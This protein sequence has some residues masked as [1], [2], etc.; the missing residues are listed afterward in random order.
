V[1]SNVRWNSNS[2]PVSSLSLI[3]IAAGLVNCNAHAATK[4]TPSLAFSASQVE[5]KTAT[6]DESGQVTQIS[7]GIALEYDQSRVD[8]DLEYSV[9]AIFYHGLDAE[10]RTDSRLNLDTTITHI[11]ET[12][13]SGID[14]QISR[15]SVDADGI[16]IVD[17]RFSSD[18]TQELRTFEVGSKYQGIFEQSIEYF[19]QIS[20]DYAEFEEEE[21]TE[22]LGIGVGIDNLASQNKL[23]WSLGLSTQKEQDEDSDQELKKA[24]LG[25]NYRLQ[26]SVS[27]FL[28]SEKSDTGDEVIDQTRTLLGVWWQPNQRTRFRV[29]AGERGD[30]STYLLDAVYSRKPLSIDANYTEEVKSGRT[31][32]LEDDSSSSGSI[33]PTLSIDPVL[34][35]QA[36]VTLNLTGRR[37]DV[38]FSLFSRT[39]EGSA[40]S[41]SEEKFDGASLAVKRTLS[42][43][44]SAQFTA[45]RQDAESGTTNKLEDL[46]LKYLKKMSKKVDMTIGM[47][48][49]RQSSSEVENR[50]NR[51]SI[52]FSIKMIF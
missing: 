43:A 42:S 31:I 22:R 40:V 5:N 26:R 2:G 10:D 21:G 52:D 27:L 35:K 28:E 1:S 37:T 50:Y 12:W 20:F 4:V 30:D 44:S 32:V 46:N 14:A 16:Q 8:L 3:L 33:G 11:P 51:G 13:E 29:G 48:K 24:E 41:G 25:L 36:R 18:N 38:G 7:P 15:R 23:T 6:K 47:R 39:L 17:D 9:D 45:S 34:E 49:T 19:A